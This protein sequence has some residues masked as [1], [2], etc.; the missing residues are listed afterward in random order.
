VVLK[1]SSRVGFPR[2][3]EASGECFLNSYLIHKAGCAYTNG[4]HKQ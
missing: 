4:H 3:G 1:V 2:F